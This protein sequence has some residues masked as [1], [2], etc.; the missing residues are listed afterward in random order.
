[1]SRHP[2]F[3]GKKAGLG[4]FSLL[5]AGMVLSGCASGSIYMSTL[6]NYPGCVARAQIS[7][8]KVDACMNSTGE[9]DFNSCLADR[10]VPQDKIDT[11]N[12]CVDS[13]RRRTIGSFF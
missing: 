11:L 7:Q 3:T 1:M 5:S 4:L 13:R 6:R 10:N 12:A 9:S 8:A 2:S